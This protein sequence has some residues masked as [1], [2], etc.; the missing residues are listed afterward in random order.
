MTLEELKRS[1]LCHDAQ[2][3]KWLSENDKDP[4]DY[5]AYFIYRMNRLFNN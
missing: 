4:N 3:N 1:V 5:E 2:I